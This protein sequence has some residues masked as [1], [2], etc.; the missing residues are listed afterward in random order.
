MVCSG[1]KTAKYYK[2][3]FGED[4]YIELQ[5]H[6]IKEELIANKGLLKIAKELDIKTVITNDSHYL[7][8]EDASWHDSL[9]CINTNA[10][11]ADKA[12]RFHF[13]NDEF[14]VKTPEELKISFTDI[15]EET[16]EQS[17]K[18]TVEVAEKC[19]VTIELGKSK[20]PYFEVPKNHTVE[21]YLDFIILWCKRCN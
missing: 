2:S 5:N 9:L 20:L 11:K 10:S 15:D 17:I 16:F 3:I 6:G 8:K 18:N 13:E 7:K 21:S 19:H 4:Y 1:L 14:Y 12:N